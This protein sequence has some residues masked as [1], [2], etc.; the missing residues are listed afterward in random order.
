VHPWRRV[1]S[2][3]L[4]KSANGTATRVTTRRRLNIDRIGVQTLRS[5]SKTDFQRQELFH[6]SDSGLLGAVT[7]RGHNISQKHDRPPSSQRRV[8][9]TGLQH[10]VTCSSLKMEMICSSE[11]SGRFENYGLLI[12][13]DSRHLLGCGSGKD[14]CSYILPHMSSI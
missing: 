10:G 13:H 1:W 14:G 5:R 11:T 2:R 6:G 8:D 3:V 4:T 12:F 9:R 7:R